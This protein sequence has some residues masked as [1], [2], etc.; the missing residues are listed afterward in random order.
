MA[1]H[2]PAWDRH[3]PIPVCTRHGAVTWVVSEVARLASGDL[4]SV[5]AVGGGR[6]QLVS[7]WAVV[8]MLWWGQVVEVVGEFGLV[9]LRAAWG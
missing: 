2:A 4:G 5:E 6:T 8:E 1:I 7:K 3:R 9:W